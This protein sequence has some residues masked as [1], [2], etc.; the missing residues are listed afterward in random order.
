METPQVPLS[1]AVLG[2]PRGRRGADELPLG[3][4]QQRAVLAALLLREG[5]PVTAPE[6]VRAVWGDA[7]PKRAVGTLRTYVS[8]LRRLLEPG[9]GGAYRVLVSVGD[10]YALRLPPGALDAAAFEAGAAAA[11]EARSRGRPDEALGLLRAALARWYGEPLAGVPGPYARAQRERLAERRLAV[12]ECRLELELELGADAALVPE[13]TALVAEH[14]LRERPRGLLMLALHRAGRHAESMAVYD[15][16]RRVLAE[17]VGLDPGRPLAGLRRRLLA[18]AAGTPGTAGTTD[19]PGTAGTT[20]T[21]GTAETAGTAGTG[22]TAGTAGTAATP[23]GAPPPAARRPAQLPGDVPDFTGRERLVEEVRAELLAEPRRAVPMVAVSGAAGVGKTALALHVAH[24][25]RAAFPGGQL[26]ADLRGAGADPADPHAVLGAFLQALGVDR[27]AIPA[28]PGERAALYRTRLDGRRVL[29]LLDDARDARQIAP[30]LPGSPSCAVLITSRSALG[31][32]GS[33]RPVGLEVMEPDEALALAGRIAGEERLAAEPAAARALLAACGHLPLAVRIAAARLAARPSWTVASL[34]E[35]LAGRRHRLTE[36]R[37]ADL[38]VEA[39]FRLGYDR[40]DPALGRAFRLL[41]LAE[42]PAFSREAAA[43]LLG[44]SVHE[45]EDLCEALVDASLLR[46]PDPGRYRYHDLL[47]LYARQCAER[48]EA[49]AERTAALRRLL[50]FY[51]ATALAAHLLVSPGDGRVRGP[52]PPDAVP[53]PAFGSADAARDWLFAEAP[54]LFAAIAQAARA[55]A[56]EGRDGGP[57][58]LL[59]A[60][61]DLLLMTDVLVSSGVH[62][63]EGEQA[64]HAVIDAAWERRDPRSEGRAHLRLGWIYYNA[65]RVEDS[66]AVCRVALRRAREA[67]DAWVVAVALGLAGACAFMMGRYEEALRRYLESLDG[68][69]RIGDPSGEGYVL[70]GLSRALLALGRYE[71]SIVAAEHG[72]ALHR[73][74]GGAQRTGYGLYH[75]GVVLRGTG[76]P[77]EATARQREAVKTF[78]A[79]RDRLGEGLALFRLAE[80]QLRL[81]RPEEAESNARRALEI[82]RGTGHAWGQGQALRVLAGALDGL[83]RTGEADACRRR[84]L[85]HFGH[86]RVPEADE[87]RTHLGRAVESPR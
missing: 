12:L 55:P 84:A 87:V 3:S 74:A 53:G 64:A 86:R 42:A 33:A 49:P 68:F 60:A 79:R 51:L 35:R 52:L 66:A 50:H 40:L 39:V 82:L 47:K 54:A 22:G 85:R 57:G 32:P 81:D 37:V 67:G 36:L 5:R 10:G 8:R 20:G 77:E 65:D 25:V 7:P 24:R 1:F 30:L 38:A 56:E 73:D 6:L 21:A 27:G 78:R 80:A 83:G 72:L 23:G 58:P 63:R 62:A 69:R 2:P 70:G 41:A 43:A 31:G 45:A 76:R 18:E 61:A 14:P 71:E 59:P 28:G 16:A 11:G 46:S 9:R 34:V 26:Y 15:E 19:I 4:P 17:E 29:V 13:L 44:T 75:L 48:D